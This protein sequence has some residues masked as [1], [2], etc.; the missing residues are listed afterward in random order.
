M[1]VLIIYSQL[2]I[3]LNKEIYKDKKSTI[4]INIFVPVS[5]FF[6]LFVTQLI[7]FPRG[8]SILLRAYENIST[9]SILTNIEYY[10][11]LPMNLI[12]NIPFSKTIYLILIV[13]YFMSMFERKTKELTAHLFVFPT[14]ALYISYPHWQGL[15]YIYP[16]LPFFVLYSFDGFKISI[17]CLKEKHQKNV[18]KLVTLIMIMIIIMSLITNFQLI[19]RNLADNKFVEGPF[20][21]VSYEMFRYIREK[22]SENSVVIFF[23]PRV[24]NLLTEHNSFMTKNCGDL[25]GAD[26]IVIHK[27]KGTYSQIDPEIITECNPNLEMN[28]VF[29]NRYFL[30]YRIEVIENN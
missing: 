13:F 7:V 15:R 11:W 14:L 19:L 6:V 8:P 20:D 4:I 28:Q 24:L 26:Y 29:E 25:P 22:T 2:A 27:F 30:I 10:F 21:K 17:N 9:N 16:I 5:T 12:K 23:K 18:K 1:T 3:F